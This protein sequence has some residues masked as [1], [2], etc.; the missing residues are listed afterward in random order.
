MSSEKNDI[1]E[2]NKNMK[3]DKIPYIIYADIEPLTK[4]IDRC[5][6][7]KNK[8]KIWWTYSLWI[9]NVNYWAFD[10][11]G[12]KHTLYREVKDH[13]HFTGK[14][15]GSACSICNL[16]LI[17]LDFLRVVFSGG[18]GGGGVGVNLTSPLPPPSYFKMN[19]SNINITSY[20]C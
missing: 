12:N 7:K 13:C 11:I 20:N 3:S 17:R 18:G 1:L 14:Y 8:H 9:F 2:L 6:N 15:R 5:A 10:N 4:N 19:L 16:T